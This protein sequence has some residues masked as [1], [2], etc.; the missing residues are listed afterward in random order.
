VLA[1]QTVGDQVRW[2]DSLQ[3]GLFN[4]GLQCV[5]IDALVFDAIGIRETELRNTTLQWHLS[6]F[7]SNLGFVA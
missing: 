5:Y 3:T 7:K 4:Q 1:R 6:T 2:R